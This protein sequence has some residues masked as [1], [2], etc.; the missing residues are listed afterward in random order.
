[1]AV[2]DIERSFP[3]LTR[4]NYKLASK[5]D[6]NYNCLAF[7]LGDQ[8]NW[9]EPPGKFGFYWPP[10]FPD[11]FA[12][13]TSIRIIQLHGYTVEWSRYDEPLSE[14]IAVY[15]NGEEWTHFAKYV[16]G[17]WLSK[18]GDDHDIAHTSLKVLEGDLYGE[19]VRVLSRPM[20]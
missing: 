18:L 14:S 8:N 5:R 15:A 9:W 13:E 10:G 20:K 1:M 16:A 17:Q 12:V 6:F 7:A 11:D 2:E 4:E 19:V 3:L